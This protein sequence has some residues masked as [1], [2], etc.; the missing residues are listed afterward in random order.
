LYWHRLNSLNGVTW[1]VITVLF[2]S[3]FIQNDGCDSNIFILLHIYTIVTVV[4]VSMLIK[5]LLNFYMRSS[6]STDMFLK[7]QHKICFIPKS[8]ISDS[9]NITK[10]LLKLLCKTFVTLPILFNLFL[11]KKFQAEFRNFISHISAEN[12]HGIMN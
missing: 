5:S 12:V 11:T 10:I 1:T 6:S 8:L 9:N 4:F 3:I 7:F 2:I